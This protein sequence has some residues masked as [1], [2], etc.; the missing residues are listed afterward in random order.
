V[1]LEAAEAIAEA[2]C[3]LFRV[4]GQKSRRRALQKLFN[5]VMEDSRQELLLRADKVLGNDRNL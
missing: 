1:L 5:Q 2:D 3:L 4:R